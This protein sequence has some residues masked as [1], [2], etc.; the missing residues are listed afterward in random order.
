[1]RP[2]ENPAETGGKLGLERPDQPAFAA[3]ANASR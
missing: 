2:E 1:M 3:F